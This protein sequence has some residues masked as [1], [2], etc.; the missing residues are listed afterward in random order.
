MLAPLRLASYNIRLRLSSTP[1]DEDRTSVTIDV[2]QRDGTAESRHTLT[3]PLLA[4]RLIV[5]E[6]RQ[7]D[8]WCS[9]VRVKAFPNWP[10]EAGWCGPETPRCPECDGGMERGEP[11]EW[12]CAWCR[13]SWVRQP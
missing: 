2:A 10:R 3:I 8:Y 11:G 7:V 1:S 9:L 5:G 4:L 13:C 12:R 6:W